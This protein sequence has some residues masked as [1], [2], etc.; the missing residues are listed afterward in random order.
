MIS[1]L[2][3]DCEQRVLNKDVLVILDTTDIRLD[4]HL[5]RIKDLE[6]I[7]LLDRNQFKASYGFLLHPLYVMDLV[8]E[9]PY[10]IA[11]VKIF[12]RTFEAKQV[13][14]AEK[15][16]I[17]W[18]SPIE[19]KESYRWVGPCVTSKQTTLSKANTV[20]Y[21]MDRE[22]DIWEVYQRIPEQGGYLVVR[23]KTNRTIINKDGETIKLHD[24]L[25]EQEALGE[26][27]L[28]YTDNQGS[29]KKSRITVKAGRCNITSPKHKPKSISKPMYYVEV[30]GERQ[31][32]K[33]QSLHWILWTNRE[34]VNMEQALQ[35]IDIYKK[36]WRVEVFFKLLKSDGYDIE[37]CQL[38]KGKSIRKLT[39]ILM[40][41]AIKIQQ[42]KAARSGQTQLQVKDVFTDCEIECLQLLNQKLEGKTD[43]QKNPNPPN[44]LSWASW[45]I[46]RLAGWKDYYSKNNPPGNK[47]FADGLE[48]FDYLM[49][50]YSIAK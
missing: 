26:Y 45:V 36:R 47:T 23:S 17:M 9:T 20:T 7:G 19:E 44:H 8:D 4:K 31:N 15:K 22:G 25:S 39:L 1:K 33:E 27:A 48:K 10:G 5:G 43:K 6:G 21:V 37:N 35:I 11:D 41:A 3:K 42:L 14:K 30:K 28:N 16:H 40:E 50:G 46:A 32:R 34:V 12:N 2:Q 24:Q 29:K 49:I 13:S 38:E 18:K